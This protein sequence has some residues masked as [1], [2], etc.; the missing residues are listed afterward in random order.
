MKMA[1]IYPAL[2]HSQESIPSLKPY[3]FSHKPGAER[4]SYSLHNDYK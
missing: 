3:L 1:S 4:P 2:T